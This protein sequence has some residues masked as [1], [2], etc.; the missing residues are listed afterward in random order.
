MTEEKVAPGGVM[1]N[2]KMKWICI[3][4]KSDEMPYCDG[5]HCSCGEK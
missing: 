1:V 5:K 3:C 2:G 4:D